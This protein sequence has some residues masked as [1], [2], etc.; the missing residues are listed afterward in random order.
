MAIDPVYK[1][2]EEEI[3]ELIVSIVEREVAIAKTK[4]CYRRPLVG[5]G[6][7]KKREFLRLRKIVGEHHIMPDDL[8]SGAQSMVAFFIPFSEEVVRANKDNPYVAR[9]WAIAYIETNDL[10]DHICQVLVR[11]LADKG[12]EAAYELP[13]GYFDEEKIVGRWSHRS[14]AAL[15]GLG[16]FGLNWLL[17]TDSGCAGRCGSL[18]LKAPL[19]PSVSEPKE[20]CLYFYDGSCTECIQHCPVNALTEKGEF[21]RATCYKYL[22]EVDTFFVDLPESEVCGKCSIGLPCSLSSAVR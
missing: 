5:F 12:I 10:I 22:L 2:E 19:I 1:M 16:S 15:V 11:N 14:V 18:L 6:K 7:V 3:K 4:T 13:V 20:R 21:Y 8:L 9:E 17:I